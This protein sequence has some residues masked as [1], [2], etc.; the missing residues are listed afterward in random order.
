M[1]VL[2]CQDEASNEELLVLVLLGE[3]RV[4]HYLLLDA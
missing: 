4:H 1:V 3:V 2:G